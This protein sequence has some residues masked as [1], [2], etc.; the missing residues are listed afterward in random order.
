M[1]IYITHDNFNYQNEKAE[2]EIYISMEARYD[3]T[4]KN[5]MLI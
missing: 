3:D 5:Y 1:Y 2:E 4:N